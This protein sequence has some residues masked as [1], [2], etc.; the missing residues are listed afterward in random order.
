MQSQIY[1]PVLIVIS[2]NIANADACRNPC[3]IPET[4]KAFQSAS[5]VFKGKVLERIDGGMTD[6]L[7]FEILN[8]WKGTVKRNQSVVAASNTCDP[9][10]D[11]ANVGDVFIVFAKS[12]RTSLDLETGF[13]NGSK[14]LVGDKNE[15]VLLETLDHLSKSD[16][17]HK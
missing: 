13:C 5:A 9:M 8:T 6:I 1:L 16:S 11:V 14:K 15:N 12:R 3:P 4:T 2:L 7:S 10:G 17:Q